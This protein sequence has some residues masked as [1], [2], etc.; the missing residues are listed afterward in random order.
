VT[1]PLAALP[2]F[3]RG[4]LGL[5]AATALATALVG[6]QPIAD[7]LRLQP[8]ALYELRGLWQPLTA[9]FVFPEGNG[10]WIVGTLLTQWF[11]GSQLE[12]FWGTRRYLALTLGCGTA[13]YLVYA[14][15]APVLPAV[16]HGGSTALDLAA[17]TAFGVVYG[18]RMFSMM[19][20]LAMRGRTLAAI[21]VAMGVLGPLLRGAP[22]PVIV[23]WL[24][25]IGGAL[26][27]TVQPW[28]RGG[29]SGTVQRPKKKPKSKTRAKH[30]RVVERDP[31]LLN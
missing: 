29:D 8:G 1:S 9:N 30:L 18:T 31:E 23:P 15:L 22:W 2:R 6:D 26:L 5:F 3:R 21:L 24:V 11:F 7:E 27:V 14:L 13:G 25:A 28:R 4:S 19:G 10:A 16:P 17:L 12:G 20:A